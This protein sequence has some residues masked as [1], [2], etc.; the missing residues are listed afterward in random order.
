MSLATT[1]K[2]RHKPH[3][4]LLRPPFPHLFHSN[5]VVSEEE[6]ALI[7]QAVHRAR[8]EATRLAEIE[9]SEGDNE[10]LYR[11][12]LACEEFIS[13]HEELLHWTRRL[14]AELLILIFICCTEGNSII[15]WNVSQV[16]R[17]WRSMALS[18]PQLWRRVHVRYDWKDESAEKQYVRYLQTDYLKRS[19]GQSIIFPLIKHNREPGYRIFH[20]LLE[21]AERWGEA[22]VETLAYGDPTFSKDIYA[23]KGRLRFLNSFH[24]KVN[25][26]WP[27]PRLPLKIL[28]EAPQLR[29]FH[30][31]VS[32]CW[33][34]GDTAAYLDW[35]WQQLTHLTLDHRHSDVFH[36]D[37]L[38]HFDNLIYLS[39]TSLFFFDTDSENLANVTFKACKYL[40]IDFSSI[41]DWNIDQDPQTLESQI[42]CPVLQHLHIIY[43]SLEGMEHM[44][45]GII[46]F[47]H[48][49]AHHLGS[50]HW[51]HH[52]LTPS[53][54]PGGGSILARVLR[55]SLP[56]LQLKVLR[57]SESLLTSYIY[58]DNA[59]SYL[60]DTLHSLVNN[61]HIFPS[62]R[63]LDIDLHLHTNRD[64]IPQICE[65]LNR[66]AL[67]EKTAVH[68]AAY[69]RPLEM[70]RLTICRRGA[71]EIFNFSTGVFESR[72]THLTQWDILSE[73]EGWSDELKDGWE[74]QVRLEAE[75][76]KV[77]IWAGA[78]DGIIDDTNEMSTTQI[79][80]TLERGLN[81]GVTDA[82]SLIVRSISDTA[83]DAQANFFW[84][85]YDILRKL[86][87]L[88]DQYRLEQENSA[89]AVLH[90]ESLFS[91]W[92][93]LFQAHLT[94]RRWA[95][96][97]KDRIIYV[98]RHSTLHQDTSTWMFGVYEDLGVAD[99]LET[100]YLPELTHLEIAS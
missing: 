36:L 43:P 90:I 99:Y 9:C 81:L 60:C 64:A 38:S 6:Y 53:N 2:R 20:A 4:R 8:L 41:P 94:S 80:D 7:V 59:V 84:K 13:K 73:L 55:E 1:T 35:P 47:F 83:C 76:E 33:V 26:V 11:R 51:Q 21:H 24:L 34:N 86:Q 72:E 71:Y 93:P 18:T 65:A 62:L 50:L 68:D 42:H 89:N 66:L 87:Q 92:T 5:S 30:L 37:L 56:L 32:G 100:G 31:D 70:I 39:L 45:F 67:L 91:Q 17:K 78:L 23:L 79:E 22:A 15:P 10:D 82:L 49:H 88:S 27:V 61:R 19:A 57:L 25:E 74:T 75:L 16:C 44:L 40:Q 69:C 54:K 95:H 77:K 85:I 96:A 48:L 97:G 12:R 52:P 14:P 29:H 58:E 98:P 3:L 28:R 63:K 46:R